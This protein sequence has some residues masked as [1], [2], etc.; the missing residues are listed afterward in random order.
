MRKVTKTVSV[1]GQ[2]ISAVK[3]MT[4]NEFPKATSGPVAVPLPFRCVCVGG[5]QDPDPFQYFAGPDWKPP[6]CKAITV[7]EA[8]T[9][10][11]NPPWKAASQL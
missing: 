3:L 7:A 11:A 1:V 4:I 6:K 5:S 2:L 9:S 8:N 10:P